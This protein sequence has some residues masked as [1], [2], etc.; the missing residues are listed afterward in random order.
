MRCAWLYVWKKKSKDIMLVTWLK[1][2]ESWGSTSEWL[3][4]TVREEWLEAWWNTWMNPQW[5]GVYMD[6]G[7]SLV[8]NSD[9]AN[10]AHHH[11]SRFL[12]Q[13]TEVVSLTDKY[14]VVRSL[15]LSTV[16]TT[17]FSWRRRKFSD[18]LG[19]QNM[20]WCLVLM[21]CLCRIICF[22]TSAVDLI[23]SER[24]STSSFLAQG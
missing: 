22:K 12:Y 2:W 6:F 19:L 16:T 1:V 20:E 4:L 18:D 24:V 17:R 5:I 14:I 21:D 10:L 9:R 15:S 8:S 23:H 11:K 3:R 7:V 13:D